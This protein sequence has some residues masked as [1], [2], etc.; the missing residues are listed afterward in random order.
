MK[1][2]KKNSYLWG[3]E[4]SNIICINKVD[5]KVSLE[6]SATQIRSDHVFDFNFHKFDKKFVIIDFD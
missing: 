5:S 1:E 6:V 2:N 4:R 3:G